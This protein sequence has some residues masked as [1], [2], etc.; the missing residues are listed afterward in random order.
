MIGCVYVYL[1]LSS[2]LQFYRFQ[3]DESLAFI[4]Y[5]LFSITFLFT[6]IY[7]IMLTIFIKNCK[8]LND[9][10]IQM[11]FGSIIGGLVIPQNDQNSKQQN[12]KQE[13][14]INESNLKTSN[15]KKFLQKIEHEKVTRQKQLQYKWS[16]YTNVIIYARKIIYMMVLLYFYGQVYFQMVII[17]SMNIFLSIY[18][19]YIKPQEEKSA[20][21]K[22]GISEVLLVIMQVTI[23]FLVK[24]DES[25]REE[26]RFNIGWIIVGSASLILSIHIFSVV[27]DLL[28]GIYNLVKDFICTLIKPKAEIEKLK[29]EK[30]AEEQNKQNK[31][32]ILT[33]QIS[34]DKLRFMKK[35]LSLVPQSQLDISMVSIQ[36]HQIKQKQILVQ[37]KNNESNHIIELH[38]QSENCDLLNKHT[39]KDEENQIKK[40]NIKFIYTQQHKQLDYKQNTIFSIK[41]YQY[42]KQL[43]TSFQK[44]IIKFLKIKQVIFSINLL[45]IRYQQIFFIKQLIYFKI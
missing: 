44:L 5:T 17:N 14:K 34:V 9:P 12:K 41:I 45:Q 25:Q 2:L 18:Y 31:F 15:E 27:V 16:R 11:Q 23:C 28:K 35:K 39:I 7:P 19:L 40:M 43:Y 13:N 42:I 22:N 26:N 4:N 38:K 30:L 32:F 8:N 36:R 37:P 20:N 29:Q 1:L 6:I 3:F 24:D 33:S 10:Q 21:I